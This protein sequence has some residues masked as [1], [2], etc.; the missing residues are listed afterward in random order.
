VRSS[1]R[2][3]AALPENNDLL[4]EA[5][6]HTLKGE[7]LLA[8]SGVENRTEAEYCFRRAI[9][10]ARRQQAKSWELR[11]VTSLSRLLQRQ[12]KYEEARRMLAE[13]YG[14]FT[15]RFDTADLKD[16]QASREELS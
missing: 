6:L 12:G 10:I 16:A 2:Q 4:F 15:E 14:W 13:I 1:D 8:S 9:D 5:E 7:L 3:N 11:A